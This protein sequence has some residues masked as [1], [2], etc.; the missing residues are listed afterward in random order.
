M[1]PAESEGGVYITTK[2]IYDEVKGMRVE[3]QSVASRV[4]DHEIRIRA[5]EKWKYGIPIAALTSVG[6]V[7][8][9]LFHTH[10]K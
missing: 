4:P 1:A 7:L 8:V 6:A 9:D 2:D 10:G 3:V 5:L